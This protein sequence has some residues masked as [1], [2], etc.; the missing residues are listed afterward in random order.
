MTLKVGDVLRR[1]T[2]HETTITILDLETRHHGPLVQWAG[3]HN[4]RTRFVKDW[5]RSSFELIPSTPPTFEVGK[6][7]VWTGATDRVNPYEILYVGKDCCFVRNSNGQELTLNK[8]VFNSYEEYIPPPPEEWRALFYRKNG[9]PEVSANYFPTK[10]DADYCWNGMT[11][12]MYAIRTDI[13]AKK[14][15]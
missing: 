12:Y 13:N 6:K 11:D 1:V 15:N 5:A 10:E 9:K 7:Y 3:K 8:N 4:C 2:D 14:E